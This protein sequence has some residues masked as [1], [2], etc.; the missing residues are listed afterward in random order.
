[1]TTWATKY[2]KCIGCGTTSVEHWA[3]GY[4]NKCYP[5]FIVRKTGDFDRNDKTFYHNFLENVKA[6]ISVTQKKRKQLSEKITDRLNKDLLH[7]LYHEENKSLQD[8]ANIFSCSRVHIYKLCKKYSVK[9]KTKSIARSDA[10]SKG[11]IVRYHYVNKD[12]FKKWSNEMAY[13][14][15]FIYADGHVNHK[16]DYFSIAQKERE[17]LDKLKKLMKAE[18]NITHYD[19]QDIYFLSIGNKEMVGDLVKLGVIPK[20]SLV[21]KFPTMSSEYVS[22]F[23]RGYFDGDGSICKSGNC[24]RASFTTGSG[25]FIN[26]VK[27]NLE[28]LVLVSIQKIYKHQTAN[29]Y[30]LY[31]HSKDDLNKLFHFFYDNYTLNNN[32]FLNRKYEN[33][34]KAVNITLPLL[35]ES[36]GGNEIT[37]LV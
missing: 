36:R 15:G 33:F 31:Y 12:F 5:K 21:V 25:E 18:Q 19:H 30:N 9:I 2:E 14:L 4:C 34:K 28:K 32:L 13:A 16:L 3:R 20:K 1:M 11:K 24:W 17:I 22:H 8:I 10:S 26:S 27:D 37:K 6:K 23:I 29:A 7:K 35:K